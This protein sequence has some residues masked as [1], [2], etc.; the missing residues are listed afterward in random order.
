MDGEAGVGLCEGGVKLGAG[1]SGGGGGL[2]HPGDQFVAMATVVLDTDGDGALQVGNLECDDDLPGR[3]FFQDRD[4]G[5][6]GQLSSVR[7]VAVS[8]SAS[9]PVR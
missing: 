1:Q 8:G 7:Q 2:G 4:Q 6:R 5:T 9:G 3:W